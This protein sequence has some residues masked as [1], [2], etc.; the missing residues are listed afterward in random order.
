MRI[1]AS[2]ARLVLF[3][4]ETW[5]TNTNF[6]SR[7]RSPEEDCLRRIFLIRWDGGY[8]PGD[9]QRTGI[10]NNSEEVRKQVDMVG[11][12]VQNATKSE[13]LCCIKMESSRPERSGKTQRI[14]RR[15]V[16]EVVLVGILGEGI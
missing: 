9:G 10:N 15:I 16:W 5:K 11:S 7:F 6:N 13:P 8:S 4:S 1:Y 2:N 14:S 12:R 3:C